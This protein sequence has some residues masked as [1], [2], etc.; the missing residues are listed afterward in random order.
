MKEIKAI[1]KP[2]YLENVLEALQS[3]DGLPGLTISEVKGMGKAQNPGHEKESF[4]AFFDFEKMVKLE[5]VVSDEKV[6]EV[7]EAIEAHARTGLKDDG[8]IFVYEVLDVV[9]IRTAQ[10]GVD[11][12]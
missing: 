1:F 7:L 4:G 8:K 11:A 5:I 2:H 10:R 9:K 12:I 3:L 6:A